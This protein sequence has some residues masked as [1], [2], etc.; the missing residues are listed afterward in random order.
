[1]EKECDAHNDMYMQRYKPPVQM[2]RH[3]LQEFVFM[4]RDSHVDSVS[5]QQYYLIYIEKASNGKSLET[6]LYRLNAFY[7]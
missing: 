3:S 2:S 4:N 1:M 7:S 6:I 5:S